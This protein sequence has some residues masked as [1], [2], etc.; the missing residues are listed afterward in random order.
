MIKFRNDYL[1]NLHSCNAFSAQ[2]FNRDILELIEVKLYGKL[3]AL[4]VHVFLQQVD[5]D[6]H[7]GLHR[8]AESYRESE[9]TSCRML[10]NS[11]DAV[12]EQANQLSFD[13]DLQSFLKENSAIFMQPP[14]F[15]FIPYNEDMV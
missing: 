11:S 14:P 10:M 7:G 8:V 5:Y 12:F 6:Y 13:S 3:C 1:L 15:T 9:H 2:Y 4:N